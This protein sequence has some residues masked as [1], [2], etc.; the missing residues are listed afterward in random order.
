[1]LSP[2]FILLYCFIASNIDGDIISSSSLQSFGIVI[3][4][5]IPVKI[6][7]SKLGVISSSR[8]EVW[9]DNF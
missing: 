4:I 8:H 1:M 6:L 9:L 3:I 7:L 5:L 2:G